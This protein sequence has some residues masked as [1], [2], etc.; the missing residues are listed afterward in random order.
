TIDTAYALL[1]GEGYIISR[2]P[3]GTIVSPELAP[4]TPAPRRRPARP[5]RAAALPAVRPLEMGLPALD[6]FPRKLWSRLV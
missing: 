3:R 2:G 5:A 1:S 6:A 4:S